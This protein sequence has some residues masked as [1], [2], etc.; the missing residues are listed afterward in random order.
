[1]L[2]KQGNHK[3]KPNI[4]FAKTEKKFNHKINGNHPAQKRIKEKHRLNW[5]TRCKMAI[6]MYLSIVTLNVNGLNAPIKRHRQ[7]GRLDKK[8]KN[9]QSA[10]YKKLTSGQR[11]HID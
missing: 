7:S 3:S 5:K 10:L 1:M 4:T 6:N 2:K 11:T 8:S 9:L